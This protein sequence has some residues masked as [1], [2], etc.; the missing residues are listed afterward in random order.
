MRMSESRRKEIKISS[1][2]GVKTQ[3]DNAHG[4]IYYLILFTLAISVGVLHSYYVGA[5]FERSRHFSHLSTLER[6][7]SFRTEMGMYYSYYK[8]IIESG[9]YVDGIYA[10]MNDNRTEYPDTINTLQRFNLYPEVI[11]AAAYKIYMSV[12]EKLNFVTKE[13]WQVDRGDS[14]PPVESCEGL[15]DPACFYVTCVWIISGITSAVIFLFGYFLS[16]SIL[17]GVM[18]VSCF[19]FNHG[20]STRVQWTPPLRESFGFPVFIAQ[21]LIVVFMLSSRNSQKII[22]A[23]TC[24]TVLF[25]L[26]WQFA[27]FVL[28]T[29]VL[30][31]LIVYVLGLMDY[32]SMRKYLDSLLVSLLIGYIMLFGN[33]F[34]ITSPL[35]CIIPA[36]YFFVFHFGQS[37][38]Q[39]IFSFVIHGFKASLCILVAVG[40]KF[41][42][43]AGNQDAHIWNLLRAKLL[44]YKD[45][46]TLLYTCAVEFGFM[47]AETPWRL[48]KT[49]LLP[50]VIF[51]SLIVFFQILRCVLQSTQ[52]S[53]MLKNEKKGAIVYV[54]VQLA[55]FTLMAILIMRLKLFFTPLLCIAASLV[56]SRKFFRCI[57]G[58]KLHVFLI[59]V[60]MGLMSIDGVKNIETQ[61]NVVG[62][63]SNVP[64]EKLFHWVQTETSTD[65]VF[66]GPMTTMANLMLSTKRRIV[67]HPHYEDN[68]ARER[69]LKVY[70][71]Y[72]RKP[73]NEVH[74]TMQQL[75]VNYAILDENWCYKSSRRGCA[76]LD[77]WD[78]QDP[79]NKGNTPLCEA[80]DI[81]PAPFKL[82]YKNSIYVVL[83]VTSNQT[84]TFEKLSS[85]S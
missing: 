39:R 85:L 63:Y 51:S 54:Y 23:F 42:L 2:N 36:V 40:I 8:T 48:T 7:M 70:S 24:L 17:G 80:V 44:L 13:C 53:E 52:S 67:N 58:P 20:E 32:A 38:H 84:N 14:L 61:W 35:F 19:F 76:M 26:F 50:V 81:N 29:Q 15:G 28:L 64:L 45:F 79:S 16:D 62:E 46:H 69:T 65:A 11:L 31:I 9:S 47:E 56:C 1:Q 12:S 57:L 25:L 33:E 71:L 10:L 4:K 30:S 49:L 34:L 75:L 18:S 82:V 83:E 68:K 77:L 72:S 43:T 41:I 66:A 21:M 6:E 60:L 59:F 78:V 3:H 73:T 5:L 55:A 37:V 22:F 27:A 74:E